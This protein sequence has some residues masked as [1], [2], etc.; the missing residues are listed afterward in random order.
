MCEQ[1]LYFVIY[2]YLVILV[3]VFLLCTFQP[4]TVSRCGFGGTEVLLVGRESGSAGPQFN[5]CARGPFC[6]PRDPEGSVE[7]ILLGRRNFRLQNSRVQTRLIFF[8]VPELSTRG[9]VSCTVQVGGRIVDVVPAG[10]ELELQ[11]KM[12]SWASRT[13]SQ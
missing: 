9:V 4:P 7:R 6:G 12:G 11:V 8:M 1:S 5:N 2:L 10:A 3:G 13:H